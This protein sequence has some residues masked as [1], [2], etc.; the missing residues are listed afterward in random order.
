[1]ALHPAVLRVEQAL[2]GL[3]CDSEIFETPESTR[4]AS[5]AA[6]VHGV[7]IGQIVKSLVFATD[8]G[9]VLALV[10]GA[11][12][13]DLEKLGALVGRSVRR[14]DADAVKEWTGFSIGGIPPVGHSRPLPAFID[15]DLFRYEAVFAAAGTPHA[16]FQTTPAEL[17]RMTGG[18]VVD[19]AE[20]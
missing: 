2:R 5:E 6:R 18:Q 20:R 17:A 7:E 14:A 16:N 15:E 4:T 3:G 10:S 9:L 13:V 12:R 19:L 11:N 8:E 1:M